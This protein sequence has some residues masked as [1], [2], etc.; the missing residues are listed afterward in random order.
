VFN[1]W[2]SSHEEGRPQQGQNI[3][4]QSTLSS[5]EE[6][7]HCGVQGHN[8]G[9]CYSLNPELHANKSTNNKDGKSKGRCGGRNDSQT[10]G[11]T[12]N[13][14]SSKTNDQG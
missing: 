14:A 6:C 1:L 5:D 7:E 10:K 8:I 13:K 9:H 11:K 4:I 2:R 3:Y 12:I